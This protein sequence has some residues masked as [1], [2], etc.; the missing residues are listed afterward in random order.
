MIS[1]SKIEDIVIT[2]HKRNAPYL[3][4]E[5]QDLGFTYESQFVTGVALKGSL[6]DCIKLNLNLHCASQI[7]YKLKAFV[8]N[9]PDDIYNEIKEIKWE[10][11]L[12]EQ[13]YMSITS[14]VMHPS[15]NNSMFANLKV[16]DAIVDR[17]REKKGIRPNTGADL[18][19][20][21]IHLFWKNETA[22]LYLDTS[23]H[24]L[25]RHGYRKIPGQAP[26][27]EALASSTILATNWDKNTPFINPMCGS[28]TLAIEAA[29]IATNRKPGLFRT[30]YGFMHI[31]GYDEEV[32]YKE[33]AMLEDQ[34]IDKPNLQ[35]I[36]SDYNDRAVENTQ[37]N[38][39][40]AGVSDLITYEHCDFEDTTVPVGGNGIV[41]LNPEYGERLGDNLELIETYE[42]I[43][44]FFKKSCAGYTG[45]IFTGNLVLGNKL[46]LKPKR[47][48]EFYNSK[49]DCRLYEYELYKG[50]KR[51]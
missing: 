29:L 36:A 49:I 20:T 11:L 43:G 10:D 42:R 12:D 6:N 16:K 14:N 19:G 46:G 34:I 18:K 45:Y 1:F 39:I 28:G 3:A 27:L 30:N 13:G 2:C 37:K 15:I 8:A 44:T 40:A 26:M 9:S 47:K 50:T 48:I 4:K 23:G 17:L 5:V 21:V 38:A 24:S 22:I 31:K 41:M 32:Y 33:D 7:L 51:I 35:I 25:G